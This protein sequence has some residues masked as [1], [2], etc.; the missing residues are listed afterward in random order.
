MHSICGPVGC[1]MWLHCKKTSV[2]STELVY[3]SCN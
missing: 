1:N 2:V 3:L